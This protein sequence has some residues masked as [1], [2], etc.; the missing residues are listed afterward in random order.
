M[1]RTG[2]Y[3]IMLSVLISLM[4]AC[5]KAQNH[6]GNKPVFT[7]QKILIVYLSRTGNTKAVAHMIQKYT[8]GRL[9]AIELEKP[10]PE[11]YRQTVDQVARENESG[12]LPPLSTKVDSIESYDVIF[13]GFPT[14]GMQ[15]P[16]P[17]KSFLNSYKLKGKQIIPFNTNGGYGIG[18]S[19]EKIKALCPD[20]K[21]MDGF[22]VT[23]GSE[24]DGKLLMIVGA[25]AVEVEA[26]VIKWLSRIGFTK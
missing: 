7:D 10:Y 17:M 25:K 16:P 11:N 15:L 5:L 14:W 8:G 23:G 3:F 19:F 12:F 1:K 24:R 22:T 9:M 20:S 21:V 13:V 18:S 6:T 4:T 26:E 2:K